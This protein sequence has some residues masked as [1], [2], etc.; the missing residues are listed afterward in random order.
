MYAVSYRP[1]ARNDYDRAIDWYGERSKAAAEN[2]ITVVE[3][4]TNSISLHPKKYRKSYREYHETSTRIYPY[5]IVYFIDELSMTVVIVR[6]YHHKRS[7]KQ[8]Y[9]K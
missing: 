8:K 2:F 1:K 7:P 4:K 3:E 9:R 6:I 5:S